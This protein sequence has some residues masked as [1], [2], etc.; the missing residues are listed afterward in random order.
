MPKWIFQKTSGDQQGVIVT[1]CLLLYLSSFL[2][3]PAIYSTG[4]YIN[5]KNFSYLWTR[6]HFIM[7]HCTVQS[8]KYSNM[9][10]PFSI[11]FTVLLSF[12]SLCSS[13]S[14]CYSKTKF[15]ARVCICASAY[16]TRQQS[17]G[18]L[19]NYVVTW[20]SL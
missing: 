6:T 19:I 17:Q 20:G 2:G 4:H 9:H 15:E 16:N 1:D 7:D 14:H 12:A 3:T 5:L 10:V 11:Q 8:P 18:P 13:S